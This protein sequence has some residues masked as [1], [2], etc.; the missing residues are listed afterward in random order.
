MTNKDRKH[1]VLI[2]IVEDNKHNRPLYKDVFE[3]KGF[4][5]MFLENA[6]GFFPEEVSKIAP[7]IISMDI[8]LSKN[9]G[10]AERD[11]FEG[12][13]ALKSDLRTAEIPVMILTNFFEE[14]KIKR[15]KELGAV[16]FINVQGQTIQNIPQFFMSYLHDPKHYNPVHPIFRSPK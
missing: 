8:M 5:V 11:G 10:P 6:D 14:N 2:L 13:Q 12:I 3:Q 16:D 1:K 4:E 7:D 9:D 15:A